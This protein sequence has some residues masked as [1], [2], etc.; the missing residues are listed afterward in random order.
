MKPLIGIN[1]DITRSSPEEASVESHYF[2][3][4]ETAGGIPVLIP[5]MP[6]DDLNELLPRLNGIMLIG[7]RDYDPK[8]YHEQATEK[9]KLLS[10]LR[11][12]FDLRLIQRAV[13]GSNIAVLGI[14]AGAQA[15]NIGLGG[16][17]IQ[18]IPTER[19]DS[20]VQHSSASGWER[21]WHEHVVHLEPKSK[22]AS[23]YPQLSF[24]VPTSHH[25][26]IKRLG[27]GLSATAHADDGIVEAVEYKDKP[28]AIGVQWHPERDFES[29]KRLFSAFIDAATHSPVASR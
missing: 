13:V 23:I 28:F 17:L 18:D 1:V 14:C 29:N 6:D 7:G 16:S 8:H 25:Q 9:V 2:K 24:E 11:D 27:A 22:L 15:L 21:G 20:S 5:P 4:I 10:P 26:A 19:P 3:A 12:D